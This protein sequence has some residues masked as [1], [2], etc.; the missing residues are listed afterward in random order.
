MKFV[1]LTPH[2]VNIYNAQPA[3]GGEVV[4]SV[5]P[6]GAVARC[7]VKR[8]SVDSGLGFPFHLSEV[9]EPDTILPVEGVVYIVSTLVRTH[10]AMVGRSDL[11]SP[12][13]A[14][15]SPEGQQIGSVGLDVNATPVGPR[16]CTCGSGEY[17]ATCGAASP[18]CG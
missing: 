3:D 13:L 5:E 16:R 15:R 6:S 14:V 2:V 10:P 17:W 8:A 4:L 18:C 1:N 7:S 12:G 11:V 9:G